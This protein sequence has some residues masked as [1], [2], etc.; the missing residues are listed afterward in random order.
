MNTLKVRQ[1]DSDGD[2]VGERWSVREGLSDG[3]TCE[4]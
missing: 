2:V 1:S 3:M 4:H